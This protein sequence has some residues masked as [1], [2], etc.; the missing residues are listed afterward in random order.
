MGGE[1]KPPPPPPP[2]LPPNALIRVGLEGPE[3]GEAGELEPE[4]EPPAVLEE[5]EEEEEKSPPLLACVVRLKE[6]PL[7]EE[8]WLRCILRLPPVPPPPPLSPTPRRDSLTKSQIRPRMNGR[9]FVAVT[10]LFCPETVS[11]RVV[12]SGATWG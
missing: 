6:L 5:E 4:P 8:P 1:A 12:E 2:L 11:V 7:L 9:L 10:R 3:E